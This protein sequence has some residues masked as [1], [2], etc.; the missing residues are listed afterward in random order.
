LYPK[1]SHPDWLGILRPGQYGTEDWHGDWNA[2]VL[3]MAKDAGSS[4]IFRSLAQGGRGWPWVTDPSRPTNRNLRP[5]LDMVPGGKL[6]ASF[7]GPLLRNDDRESGD[8]P[9][10]P[11]IKAFVDDLF[12]WTVDN[13]QNVQV[14]AVL[15]R[16]AWVAVTRSAGCPEGFAQWKRRHTSGLP[17]DVAV[18]GKQLSLFALNHPARIPATALMAQAG[19]RRILSELDVTL[20]PAMTSPANAR[21]SR[22]TPSGVTAE[23]QEDVHWTD[24][25]ARRAPRQRP[26]NIR[27]AILDILS[28]AGASGSTADSFAALPWRDGFRYD[29]LRVAM[30]LL[31]G[32]T[33]LLI[34]HQG[35]LADGTP[36]RYRLRD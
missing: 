2:R 16:E 5:L 17:L 27:A 12:R 1:N 14:V 11:A 15:G 10:T 26:V 4:R 36:A 33:G 8:L 29:K 28:R 6:Y 21:V 34:Q 35:Q 20:R 30:A 9:S 24:L 19:W 13:M 23:S 25:H 32:E 22:K 18:S 7:L 31:A 3:F